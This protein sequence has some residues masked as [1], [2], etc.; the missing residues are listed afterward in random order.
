MAVEAIQKVTQ[1]EQEAK[2]RKEAASAEG[3]QKIL[4]TQRAAQRLLE[5]A[6]ANAETEVRQMMAQAEEQAAQSASQVLEQARQESE[7][8]KQT[9]RKRLDLA[10][11]LIVE[12]VVKR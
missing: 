5:E 10:A 4:V 2:R 3:K 12:K 6:R 7:A 11:E 9:A 1:I 8:M